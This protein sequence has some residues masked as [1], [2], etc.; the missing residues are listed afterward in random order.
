MTRTI[1]V[2]RKTVTLPETIV[3]RAIEWAAPQWA[4]RRLQ[5][6]VTMAAVGGYH[7]GKTDRRALTAWHRSGGS[8]D[9]DTLGELQTLRAGSRDLVRNSP[10]AG[11]AISTTT[12][13]VVGT[14][15]TLQ[16][17][18]DAEAL[19]MD[20][21]EAAA[22][23]R[24]TERE[25]R[26]FSESPDCDVTRR[27]NLYGLQTLAFRST[28]ESGDV[29]CLLPHVR[30]PGR[31]YTLALQLVEAD[32]LSN[33]TFKPDTPA[34]SS[35]VEMDGF[36]APVAYHVCRTHPGD[37]MSV[38]RQWDRVPAYGPSSGRKNVI[39][40]YTQLRIGQTRGVPYLAPVIEPLKQ[41]ERYTDAEIM[42]AVISGMFTVFVKTTGEGLSP[43]DNATSANTGSNSQVAGWDGKLGNGLIVDLADGESIETAN[44][45]RPNAN[46]DPFVQAIVQQIG[47]ALELPFEVLMKHFQSSYS[48]ARAALLD[49][50]RF[51]RCRRDWLAENF[52]KP[53]YEAWMDEAVA[54]GRIA[55]PGY[56]SSPAIRKA[57]LGSR[58]IGDA[59][60]SIDPLKEVNAAEKRLDI[61]ISTL[62]DESVAYDGGDWEPKHR[63]QVKERAMRKEGGLLPEA[64]VAPNAAPVDPLNDSAAGDES[65]TEEGD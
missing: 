27:Q 18:I 34:L 29:L 14:G 17:Q 2:G 13:N 55:A 58:W 65:T 43:L 23:Q 16:S 30:R 42:A 5:S 22:W 48:A 15:L 62:A 52:C 47:V 4:A 63:Q 21:E 37:L 9:A 25:F 50:W 24:T 44:P 46:F 10:I 36:G 64:P 38:T 60:G 39:H 11:G 59:P 33:P 45:G 3:D 57:Y 31:D 49:A 61:G 40:L 32:R 1:R 6:R 41:L 19:G 53:V 28:L 20:D 26:L 56:F 51:F 12:T 8:A 35:G 54:M 7:G